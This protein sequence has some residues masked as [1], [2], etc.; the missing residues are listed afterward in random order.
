MQTLKQLESLAFI[1]LK[2]TKIK[3]YFCLNH[4][5]VETSNV[6]TTSPYIHYIEYNAESYLQQFNKSI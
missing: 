4:S 5:N 1:L 6:K 2:I 3:S